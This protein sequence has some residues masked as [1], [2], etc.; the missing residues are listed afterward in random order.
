MYDLPYL[1]RNGNKEEIVRLLQQGADINNLGSNG[2]T[3]LHYA[4]WQNH[5]E[6][7]E[8]LLQNKKINVNLQ[9]IDGYSPFSAACANS[10][11]CSLLMVQDPRVDINLANNNDG[12]SPLMIAC[13]YG[14]TKTVQLLLSSGRNIDILKKTTKYDHYSD[15]ES[16]STALDIA[17]QEK[18]YDVVQLLQQYQNNPK[19]TQKTTRNE[20]NLKGNKIKYNI[21]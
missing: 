21:K 17:K 3:A 5:T 1:A 6:I 16:D 14:Y 12:W 18:K 9:D 4:C 2:Y 13:R 11:E 19:E 7:T 20:L 10:Y 15:T 8:I